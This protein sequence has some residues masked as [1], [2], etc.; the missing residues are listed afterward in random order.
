M[1]IVI[2]IYILLNI[3]VHIDIF[4]C[5]YIYVY[6]CIY[7]YICVCSIYWFILPACI[8]EIIQRKQLYRSTYIYIYILIH[9]W[10]IHTDTHAYTHTHIHTYIY[11]YTYTYNTYCI[12]T[13]YVYVPCMEC[14]YGLCPWHGPLRPIRMLAKLENN[15]AAK[16]GSSTR[17][18][19]NASYGCLSNMYF[20]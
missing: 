8:S 14:N 3:N 6:I 11:I 15:V 4:V 5:I 1:C 2:Y 17:P 13:W 10:H 18:T 16:I 9:T 19:S 20:K 12:Y 7:I